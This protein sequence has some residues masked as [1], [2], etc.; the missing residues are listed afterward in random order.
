MGEGGLTAVWNFSENS[1]VFEGTGFP[2][3]T[4]QKIQCNISATTAIKIIKQQQKL[5]NDFKWLCVYSQEV[6]KCRHIYEVMIIQL[7]PT[8]TI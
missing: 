8:V 6:L 3:V 4:Q 1:S 7:F 5:H 2:K